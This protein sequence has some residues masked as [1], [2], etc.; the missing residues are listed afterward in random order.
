ME[1]LDR[2]TFILSLFVAVAVILV[3]VYYITLPLHKNEAPKAPRREVP[4]ALPSSP[5]I[6]DVKS[7]AEASSILESG[8]KVVLL[9]T[10]WCGHCRNMMPSFVEAASKN[11]KVKWVRVDGNTAPSLVKR[12]DVKGFPTVFGVDSQGKV[13]QMNG[14]RDVA[15]LLNFAEAQVKVIEEE[16]SSEEEK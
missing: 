1:S 16:V 11:D 6:T 2:K 9:H 8:P 4:A 14:G 5:H 13:T 15:S 12:G 10:P 7:D 3:G